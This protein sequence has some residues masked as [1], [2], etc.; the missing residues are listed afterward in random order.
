M[1]RNHIRNTVAAM[2]CASLVI[3]AIAACSSDGAG[4]EPTARSTSAVIGQPALIGQWDFSAGSG[5]SA[6]DSSGSGLTGQL[7]SAA[8]AD[9]SDPSWVALPAGVGVPSELPPSALSFA[10]SGDSDFVKIA[11]NAKLD[12]ARVSVEMWMK[13]N[14]T[15]TTNAYLLA[16][17]AEGC[18]SA[19]Y[20]LYASPSG[21]RFGFR[22]QGGGW[23]DS[24]A[25]AIASVVDNNWHHVVGTY[26]GSSLKLYVDGALVGTTAV[27]AT[28]KYGLS[29]HN[30]L[31]IGSY[32]S[33]C[34][35]G[36]DGILDG[37]RVYDEAL[38]ASDVTERFGGE[39]TLVGDW[40][41]DEGTGQST[42][43]ST[44]NGLT[45][46][47]GSTASGDA[48]DPLWIAVSGGAGIPV[49]IPPFALSFPTN[50]FVKV[51]NS[52]RLERQKLSVE[53]WMK[54]SSMASGNEYLLAKGA[55]GCSYASYA[56]YK[57]GN[58]L[59]FG[60]AD[61]GGNWLEAPAKPLAAVADDKW[62]HVVGTADGANLKL[63][64]DGAFVG[65]TA[66]AGTIKYGLGTH[67]D[68]TIGSYH[69]SCQLPFKGA[70]DE[71]RYY[72]GALSASEV[73]ARFAESGPPPPAGPLSLI[74]QYSFR[75][76]S[77]QIAYDSSVN[78]LDGVL[79]STLS[80]EFVDESDPTWIS[81]P[82]APLELRPTALRFNGSGPSDYVKVANRARLERN[83]L[84]VEL[85]MRTNNWPTTN[86]YLI[87]KGAQG[88]QS[89]SYAIYN[90]PTGLRFGARDLSG[91]WR[92]TPAKPLAA[93]VDGA[94]HHVVGTYDGASLKLYVDGALVG[95]TAMSG[96]IQYELSSHNDLYIGTY[97]SEACTLGYTGALDEVRL[98]REALSASQVTLRMAGTELNDADQDGS[99]NPL[100]RCDNTP[101]SLTNYP[102]DFIANARGCSVSQCCPV[103]GPRQIAD[104]GCP[105]VVWTSTWE[106]HGSYVSCVSSV[107]KQLFNQGKL[108]KA[109]ASAISS[110]A[111][112]T[113][114]GKD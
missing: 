28:I 96:A 59:H 46:Q 105:K 4:P 103:S 66:F 95:G 98:Y 53:L 91:T 23:H 58:G 77:G 108:T 68:L 9:G 75:T 47:L 80:T 69:S 54:S 17:G 14:V 71:V 78:N 104:G 40:R 19:S 114:I 13:T 43:D 12:T 72:Q 20:G 34:T 84:S 37:V 32:K 113:D 49:D 63:Y 27:S 89:A 109:E 99:M 22:D 39:P 2:A 6:V 107:T 55:H 30:D 73:S 111:A 15:P 112:Q 7:G 51:A 88:C 26:D 101:S 62:H 10:S 31:L 48:F 90:S 86:A 82:N 42:A 67:N 81:V 93:V 36:Y 56:I 94:W 102:L 61:T 85:W 50:Q 57:D 60:V 97:T 106:T 18:S 29:T 16:K 100:D 24:P 65:Q 45:G 76:G 44:G 92:D 87:S 38:S 70:L 33:T 83:R 64:F 5:Q 8:G 52:A 74:A 1:I 41:F 21:L 11:N 79:G 35:L 25:K 3:G 110:A